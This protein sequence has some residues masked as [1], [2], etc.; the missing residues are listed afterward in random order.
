MPSREKPV[1]KAKTVL[2]FI[3]LGLSIHIYI[4]NMWK[5]EDV[6][7]V[8]RN[9][10]TKKIAAVLVSIIMVLCGLGVGGFT[11]EAVTGAKYTVTIAAADGVSGYF[12]TVEQLNGSDQVIGAPVSYNTVQTGTEVN[13]DS[14]AS[15][16]RITVHKGNG[17]VVT[18]S[19]NIAGI[20]LAAFGQFDNSA[21]PVP[22]VDDSQVVN[23]SLTL[24]T[25]GSGGNP[26]PGGDPG[27]G[28]GN[29]R[30]TVYHT[31]NMVD[32]SG[33]PAIEISVNDNHPNLNNDQ[34]LI[35]PGTTVSYNWND[36]DKVRIGFHCLFIYVPTS[37]TI[38]GTKVLAAAP[39]NQK[40]LE[41]YSQQMYHFYYDVPKADTYNIS[42]EAVRANASNTPI[43]NFLWNYDHPGDDYVS[44]ARLEVVSVEYNGEKI[45]TAGTGSPAIYGGAQEWDNDITDG[46][47]DRIGS[48]TL[49]A[50]AIVTMR[51]IPEYGYQLV[52]F[53]VN[54]GNFEAQETPCVYTFEVAPGNFHL[55][56]DFEPV[57]NEVDADSTNV[58]SGGSVVLN[59]AESS[60]EAGTA[61]LDV[62]DA[63][64]EPA[65]ISGFEGAAAG[66]RVTN[67]L[68]IS[69][70]NTIY[71][72]SEAESWDTQVHNL[73]NSATITLQLA[74]GVDGNEVV[75]VHEVSP[76]VYETIPTVYDPVA[77][78]ITFTTRGFSN[79]AIASRTVET[80]DNSNSS[81]GL[82][83]R[84][85][86]T[87]YPEFPAMAVISALFGAVLV[88]YGIKKGRIT[89]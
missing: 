78:T 11:S 88:S 60:M 10:L 26:G 53:G 89:G 13:I 40:L 3:C 38:N 27:Q 21:Q 70:F 76:G 83:T 39:S 59:G 79:Y 9:G 71:Q 74:A 25:A 64:L 72:G 54:D 56:A 43:G 24:Q 23:I 80:T 68:D 20:D 46:N 61:R 31:T 42:T 48:A 4:N 37:I 35:A 47:G 69:L 81:E 49:P 15:K 36:G 14:S 62:S 1:K 41:N 52:N 63:N 75:I 73:D 22:L 58:V 28:G 67:Y 8:M 18:A 77:R 65:Q 87:G 85:P 32:S 66:Y 17:E 84:A 16:L 29:T 45:D 12:V 57:E 5:T 34:A 55:Y 44:H 19:T 7:S 6:D 2:K 86:K 51:L 82:P 33:H 50:G 30:S